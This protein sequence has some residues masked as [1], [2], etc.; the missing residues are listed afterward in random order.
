MSMNVSTNGTSNARQTQ[1]PDIYD[2]DNKGGVKKNGETINSK[3]ANTELALYGLQ[4]EQSAYTS[5]DGKPVDPSTVQ[6]VTSF[7]GDVPLPDI[8]GP[9]AS[10]SDVSANISNL[11]SYD[12]GGAG[13]LMWQ[14]LSEMVRGSR[15]DMKIATELRNAL[16]K[17]KLQSKQAQINSTESQ[18]EADRKAAVQ[19][20]VVQLGVAGLTATMGR[21]DS[22]M[23]KAAA[24]A[25]GQVV[26][27]AGTAWVKIYGAGRDADEA[28]LLT[29]RQEMMEAIDDQGIESAK[30]NY[31]DA[32]EQ[33]KLALRIL[34]E[35]SERMSQVVQKITS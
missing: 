15:L 31:E 3:Q 8:S 12:D 34:T 13:A 2:L 29:K 9:T 28:K 1:P 4:V 10:A 35:T 17:A 21:S 11:G 22:E 33:H 18:L 20:L 30:S 19:N 23:M 5:I 14:S 25:A 24:G 6:A 27:A 32:K 7:G 16:Q 26:G